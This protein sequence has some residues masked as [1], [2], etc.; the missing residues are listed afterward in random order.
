MK[1]G[2]SALFLG[3][4][5][6]AQ[7]PS[8]SAQGASVSIAGLLQAL[9][10]GLTSIPIPGFGTFGGLS[11]STLNSL[12]IISSITIPEIGPIG[13]LPV[14]GSITVLDGLTLIESIAPLQVP[15]LPGLPGV[16]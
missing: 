15:I 1:K 7:A 2:L 8:A 5:L 11:L 16:H 10:P 9:A 14:V 3:L 4:A 13:S 6:C 12:P